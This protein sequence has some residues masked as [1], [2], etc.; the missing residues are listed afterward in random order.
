M[1]P[2]WRGRAGVWVARGLGG[3]EVE[4][5]GRGR[6]VPEKWVVFNSGP[7]AGSEPLFQG[8]DPL[9]SKLNV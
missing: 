8:A 7:L 9:H 2:S 3:Q 1:L 6:L 4:G 5:G